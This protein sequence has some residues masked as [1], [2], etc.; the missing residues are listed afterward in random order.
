MVRIVETTNIQGKN[1][2]FWVKGGERWAGLVVAKEKQ[3]ATTATVGS[4]EDPVL[5][6]GL[7]INFFFLS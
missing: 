6:T 3:A 7:W 1:C 5:K 2:M 4:F